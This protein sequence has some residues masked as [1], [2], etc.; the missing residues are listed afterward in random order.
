MPFPR[1]RFTVRRLMVAVAIVA[2]VSAMLIRAAWFRALS[3]HHRSRIILVGPPSPQLE[4]TLYHMEMSNKYAKA[5]SH[6]W[7]PVASDPPEPE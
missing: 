5:A 3:D 6:P 7:L 4:R 2:V 1:V